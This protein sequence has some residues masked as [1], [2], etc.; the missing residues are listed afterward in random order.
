MRNQPVRMSGKKLITVSA[1][2]LTHVITG[3]SQDART[4]W[5]NENAY[6]VAA[7]T[8]SSTADLHFLDGELKNNVVFG[9][10]EASHGTKEFFN[11][12]R[13][14]VAYLVV[15]LNYKRLGFE[16]NS[17]YIDPLNQYVINGTGD[18]KTLMKD[19]ML[20]NTTEIYDLFQFIKRYNDGQPAS[21]KVN[22]FGFD[23]EEYAG[24]PFNRD[25]FMADNIIADQA[26]HPL[27][28]IIWAH[29]VHIAKDTTMAQFKA[30]GYYLQQAFKHNFYV[31]GFDT[32]KGSVTVITENGLAA[33]D[34]DMQKESF[35]EIFATANQPMLFIP[36]HKTPN[37]FTGV[38]NN[39]TNIYANWTPRRTL[40]MIPG[41][42]FDAVLFIKTT[43]ASNI[44]AADK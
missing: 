32:F 30:M 15:H 7:D 18:L 44:M 24:D 10:G 20:Y 40:P 6:V 9:L 39:I 8:T 3:Y 38:K 37:P 27:K 41:A 23:R 21:E 14:I 5:I 36:F 16:F 29:N 4:Q 28:T 34:F 13:R 31:L 26:A 35:A 1:L 43:T 2:L 42:D 17:S 25:K 33:K 12:K 19:M 22:L 11:Q